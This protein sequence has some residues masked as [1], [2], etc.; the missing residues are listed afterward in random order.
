MGTFNAR[1]AVREAPGTSWLY[2]TGDTMTLSLVLQRAMAGRFGERY[3]WPALFDPIGATRVTL[4]RDAVATFGGGSYWYASARDA[5]R[6]GF[7][8]QNDGCWNGTRL[9]PEGWVQQS[10]VPNPAFI[11]KR[12]DARPTDVYG[13]LLWLNRAVPEADIPKPWPAL[14]DDFYAARGHW[15]QSISVVPSQD[16]VVV[17]FADDRDEEAFDLG[18]FHVLAL[19]VANAATT[20][21]TMTTATTTT[22]TT[23][24]ATPV[25]PE[26][27]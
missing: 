3:P 24:T 2:S 11:H 17:R 19:A 26:Q 14:P 1:H 23:T 5:A 9:L 13:R 6:L 25:T 15:G 27:P 22:T 16:V 8:L 20:T 10:T 21:A 7:L 18:R 12:L 4:E